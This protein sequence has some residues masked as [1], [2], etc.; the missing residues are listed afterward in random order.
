M[1]SVLGD[2]GFCQSVKETTQKKGHILDWVMC[3]EDDDVLKSTTVT[4][5]LKSD[6]FTIMLQFGVSVPT[7]TPTYKEVRNLRAIDRLSFKEDVKQSVPSPV[8]ADDLNNILKTALDKHAPIS[9]RLIRPDKEEGWYSDVSE[10]LQAAKR[11][12]RRAENLADK[13]GLTVHKQLFNVAKRAV[14]KIVSNAKTVHNSERILKCPINKVFT[15][16][17]DMCGD[18]GTS[19]LPTNYPTAD[20]AETFI[21]FFTKKIDDI[22]ADLVDQ[23]DGT[24]FSSLERFKKGCSSSF[25]SFTEV[26]ESDIFMI[27]RESKTTT[28]CLDPIPT[29]LFVECLD[30][31]MPSIVNIVNVSLRTGVVPTLYKTAVVKPLIKKPNLDCN[32]LKHYRPVSNLSYLSKLVERVVQKQFLAYLDTH[33]LLPASQSAYRPHHSTETALVK[34]TNDILLAMDQGQMTALTLLDLSAAFDTIDHEILLE[35]L[36]SLYGITGMALN[37]VR[38]YLGDRSQYVSV[39]GHS[40]R[41]APLHFGVPQGSVLGPIL[42]IMYTKPLTTLIDGY[43]LPSQSYADDTQTYASSPPCGIQLTT[44]RL[45]NCISDVKLWMVQNKLKLND[46]K[47]ECLLIKKSSQPDPS[48]TS[49]TIG[50]SKIPFSDCAKDLGFFVSSDELCLDMQIKAMCQAANWQLRRIGSIRRFLTFEATK[51]L[52]CSLVLSRLD[53]H[54]ALL[55]GCAQKYTDR[56]QVVQN[57]AARLIFRVRKRDHV[58]PLLRELH[59]LP[60]KARIQYKLCTLCYHFFDGT[61]PAY[62]DTLLSRYVCGRPGNRSNAD[63][64]L[65]RQIRKDLN[66]VTIGERSFAHCGP[67]AWNSLPYHVR[68]KPTI[69]SFRQELKT[70]LFRKYAAA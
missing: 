21:N 4:H 65:L 5:K 46:D 44:E 15:I 55:S 66:T 23:A 37:W 8:S 69:A 51:T 56:L 30:V 59:W 40:S 7:M 49:V 26:T 53:F 6:H 13:S 36:Q 57:S 48:I 22:S 16:A 17:N 38:S 47:T 41:L 68:H 19:T 32:Q 18:L 60:I 50:D 42:F 67:E 14:I 11:E 45:E 9:N 54:N 61:C 2:F 31:L 58:S 29:D 35:T 64:R 12:R 20:L 63:T 34:I 25:D 27:V 70:H 10:E 33:K 24:D 3:R 1:L 39:H 43:T 28:C 52:V 62:F